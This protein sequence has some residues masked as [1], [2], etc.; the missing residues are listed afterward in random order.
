[1]EATRMLMR[2]VGEAVAVAA[3]A[4]LVVMAVA[5]RL[6]PSPAEP[7]SSIGA[8]LSASIGID[9]SGRQ[10]T[11]ILFLQSDCPYCHESLP[12]YQRL[13]AP[14]RTDVQIVVAAPASDARI[15]AYLIMQGIKPDAVIYVERS[16][17]PVS[18]TPTLLVVDSDGAITHSWIGLL[19]AEREAEVLDVLFD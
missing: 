8:V 11:L 18:A 7:P 12:F 10:Q 3:I 16:D 13:L 2:F 17:L 4:V 5:G 19:D 15:R 1:M 9:F 14:D 6:F